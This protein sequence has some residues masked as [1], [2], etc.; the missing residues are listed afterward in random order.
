L[1]AARTA[2]LLLLSG[3]AIAGGGCGKA[4]SPSPAEQALE[5][6]DLV[7]VSRALQS[8]EGQTNAEV[9]ATRAAWPFVVNGLPKRRTG[10]YPPQ[11]R[12][13]IEMAARL[14]LP[15]LFGEKQATELT[16][17][18]SAITGL[19]RAFTGLTSR[20]WQMIGAAIY[21][22]EHGQRPSARFARANVA[23]YIDG[24]YDGHFGLA[25]IGKKLL[26]AYKKLGGEKVFG[27]ALTQAEVNAIAD[28]Y[29]EPR[30]RLE[31]HVGVKLGS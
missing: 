29:S 26:A 10:L 3:A 9:A 16:G 20:G 1:G 13:A 5:R 7:F 2:A 8:L 6:E 30:D 15:T 21:Q 31:P 18:A 12:A 17:S 28:A 25:Q 23:L 4:S 27:I 19:Y 11:V 22:I 14:Q 24:L